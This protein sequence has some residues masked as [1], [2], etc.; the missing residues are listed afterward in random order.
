MKNTHTN[1]NIKKKKTNDNIKNI[2][3]N[4]KT[5]KKKYEQ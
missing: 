3:K 2:I 4:M 1:N 5:E